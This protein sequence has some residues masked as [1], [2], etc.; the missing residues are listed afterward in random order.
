LA[1]LVYALL[2]PASMPLKIADGKAFAAHDL[3]LT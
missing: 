2:Q 3:A 1:R